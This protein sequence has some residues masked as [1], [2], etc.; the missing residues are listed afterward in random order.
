MPLDVLERRVEDDEPA[1][2]ELA[3]V[4]MGAGRFCGCGE[5]RRAVAPA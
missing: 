4:L 5:Q 3:V 2:A 1:V